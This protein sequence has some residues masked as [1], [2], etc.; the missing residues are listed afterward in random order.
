MRSGGAELDLG[1]ALLPD[2]DRVVQDVIPQRFG[3]R[4]AD[5]EALRGRVTSVQGRERRGRRGRRGV[6]RRFG[7]AGHELHICVITEHDCVVKPPATAPQNVI[8]PPE[9]AVDRLRNVP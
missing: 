6:G 3:Q 7:E 2:D 8:Q 1:E 4:I 9:I 5:G